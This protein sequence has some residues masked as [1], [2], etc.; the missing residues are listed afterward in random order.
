MDIVIIQKLH[1][2][3]NCLRKASLTSIGKFCLAI[4]VKHIIYTYFNL[5]SVLEI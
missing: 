1:S 3:Q 2:K 5:L 4:N